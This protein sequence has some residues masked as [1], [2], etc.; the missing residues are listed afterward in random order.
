MH[1]RR[2]GK[3]P[4]QLSAIGFGTAQL[5]LVPERQ[6]LATLRR[7]FELGVNWAHAAPDYGGA[8]ELVARAIRESGRDDLILA[9]VCYQDRPTCERLFDSTCRMLGKDRLDLYGIACID[10]REFSGENVWEPGGQVEFLTGL[11]AQGRIGA[12]YC[13]THAP[14]DRVAKLIE[15][16]VFDAIMLAYNPLGFHV[17]SY[18]AQSEGKEYEDLAE[19]ARRIFPL[20]ERHQVSLLVMKPFAGG[21][22]GGGGKAFPARH[23]FSSAATQVSATDLLRSILAQPGVAAVCPGTASLEEAEEN[24]RA[25]HALAPPEPE[26]QQRLDH[27]VDTMRGELCSRCGECEPSCSKQ[28]QISWMVREAYMW[29]HPG[30]SFETIDRHHYF[31]RHPS[32]ALACATCTERTC[33]CP[34][35][36]DIPDLLTRAHQ[37]VLRYRADGAMHN[38]PADREQLTFAGHVKGRIVLAGMPRQV[39]PRTRTSAQLWLEN[40]GPRRWSPTLR[41]AS[42]D[43]VHLRITAPAVGLIDVPLRHLVEPQ[44]RTVFVFELPAIDRPGTYRWTAELVS[45]P[46][47][48]SPAT[49]TRVHTGDLT[50]Q[51]PNARVPSLGD[52]VRTLASYGARYLDWTTPQRAAPGARVPLR[53]VIE[54]TGT[55]TWRAHAPLGN[56]ISVGVFCDGVILATL[57]LPRPEVATGESVTLQQH[58]VLPSE[59]GDH[60]LRFELVEQ[61]LVRF[62]DRAV[63]PLDVPLVIDAALDDPNER[64]LQ[65][66]RRV[67]PWHYHPTGGVGTAQDGTRFP[68][69]AARAKG[70]HIW[71]VT[72]RQY[73]DYTM[74]WGTTV[75]GYAHPHVQEALRKAIESAPLL[76]YAQPVELEVADLLVQQFPG[77]EI[78]VFGKNG[79]DVCT[80]AARIA[81]VT[82]G[83]KTILYCGYHGWG[84]FWVEQHPFERTGVP[85]R[86]TPLIHR[87][88]WNDPAAFLELFERTRHDLACVMLEPSGPW[89]GNDVGHE[90]DID[91]AF[92][93]LLRA[94][95]TAAGA[96]LVF[97]EIITGF[98]YL[99][100]SV[101]RARNVRPD[102]TC[103]GKAL[104][105]GMPLS[106]LLGPADLMRSGYP[107]SHLGPT[108]R[109][110][111]YSFHAARATL[112]VLRREPVPHTIWQ[113]GER[114]RE[115]IDLALREQHLNAWMKGPPFRMSL[116]F[117]EPDARRKLEMRTLFQQEMLRKGIS[118]FGNGVMVPCFV[119]DDA[120]LGATLAAIRHAAGMVALGVRENDL[121]RHIEIPLLA[122]M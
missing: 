19:N 68:V 80:L 118:M 1:Y 81:R 117:D 104:A 13:T 56:R 96:L 34:Y 62:T 64:L 75:L 31:A 46:H 16:G 72:D 60:V 35:G 85:T 28:L 7:G 57:E 93:E 91:Q 38:T 112:Q 90:S 45:P 15:C 12:I 2:I 110:E 100:G 54:N 26:R 53:V 86:E 119:H 83:R 116:F 92:L 42:H 32:T 94:K 41:D 21:L 73:I 87:F 61:E 50:V 95:T 59:P 109:E 99:Q 23:Q 10:D 17:L 66:A 58:V 3:T 4:L 82:T 67:S 74:G 76:A 115:G 113:H 89:G 51:D 70:Y 49:S 71:D 55:M 47:G 5:R 24:A 102:L 25:G 29:S 77:S 9:S 44:E 120:A 121:Q 107:R 88:R 27:A 43:H 37:Q 18:H 106:A 78:A 114:L 79:S 30:D 8:E 33:E 105:S 14:P 11:K 36:L 108:F 84:D 111:A 63:P 65:I 20:A 40:G 103:L 69:F 39:A 6:A 101:Q 22:L 52:E 97:D 48:G 98:R 122:D